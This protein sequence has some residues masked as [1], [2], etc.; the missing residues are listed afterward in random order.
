MAGHPASPPAVS[1]G[2]QPW[3]DASAETRWMG[4]ASCAARACHGGV[5]PPLSQHTTW[6][7]RDKHARASAVLS[8]PLSLQI[9][10]NLGI[11]QAHTSD[12]CLACHAP[13][14]MVPHGP[15][16]NAVDGVDCESCHGPAEKWLEPHQRPDFHA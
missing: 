5:E 7:S 9:A 14:A 10:R 6:I 16:Y 12:R 11:E 3:A 15:R 4:A 13:G 1:L 8:E 2:V